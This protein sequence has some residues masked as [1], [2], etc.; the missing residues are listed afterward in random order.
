[1]AVMYPWKVV[2]QWDRLVG[3]LIWRLCLTERGEL[4]QCLS[5]FSCG[6]HRI[7]PKLQTAGGLEEDKNKNKLLWKPVHYHREWVYEYL[8]WTGRCHSV[9]T[10]TLFSMLGFMCRDWFYS[11]GSGMLLYVEP[12]VMFYCTIAIQIYL[13]KCSL[14]AIW[15]TYST[16]QYHTQSS[17]VPERMIFGHA[18]HILYDTH[19]IP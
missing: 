17:V 11:N 14:R 16:V 19:N 2:Y 5:T 4:L 8:S 15:L 13:A 10:P 9:F 3:G 12:S 18:V 1:M 6:R 7:G